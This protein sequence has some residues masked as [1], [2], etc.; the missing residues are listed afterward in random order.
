MSKSIYHRRKHKMKRSLSI[1]LVV[2][3]VLIVGITPVLAHNLKV[4]L[5]A[6]N[7]TAWDLFGHSVAIDGDTALVGASRAA[8]PLKTGSAYVFVSDGNTWTEQAQLT[9]SDGTAGNYFGGGVSIDGDT[10]LVSAIGDNAGIGSAYV[11]VRDGTSWTEQAKLNASDGPP[12]GFFGN[13]VSICGDTALVSATNDASSTWTGSVYVFVRDGTTWTEQAKLTA[14]DSIENHFFGWSVSLDE[15]TALI[16]AIGDGDF[17]GSAYI[18]TRNGSTWTEKA[19]LTASDGVKW[20]NLGISV[21]LDGDT[22]L[23]G[24][25]VHPQFQMVLGAPSIIGS[26][27]VFV[28]EDTNWTEQ[29]KLSASDES[30]GDNFGWSVSLD[31]DTALIGASGDDDKGDNSGSAYVFMRSDTIWTERGKLTAS[32]GAEEDHFGYWL[33][34]GGDIALV[35]SNGDD[36][37]GLYSG[38]AYIYNLLLYSLIDDVSNVNMS[39]GIENSLDAKLSVVMR[40]LDDL[41]DNNDVAAINALEAFINEVE[42]QRGKKITTEDADYLIARGLAIIEVLT[43]GA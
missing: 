12:G 39:Q 10:A 25:T 16:G 35:G 30:I 28:G 7:A 13:S 26:A 20:D 8:D 15:D 38:S 32:D 42:A 1:C 11:F 6:S 17:I 41:L 14:S 2:V 27:Y 4:K 9:A 33:S 29:A 37:N 24:A 23:V 40:A 18:F 21:S 34:L 22:A 31:G 5:T 19:K 36:V 43:F 3:I